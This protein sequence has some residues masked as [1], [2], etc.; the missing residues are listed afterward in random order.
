MTFYP[1][2]KYRFL[3]PF[4]DLIIRILVPEL[5]I[6]KRITDTINPESG[7]RILDF[8]CGTGTLCSLILQRAPEASIIGAD[9]DPYM[10]NLARKKYLNIQFV[11]TDGVQIPFPN[12]CFDK[13]V[14]SWTFHH[15][16]ENEKIHHLHEIL[17]VLKPGG[18]FL[19]ADWTE[20]ESFQEKLGFWLV[21]VLDNFE[22]FKD[23]QEGKIPE[24]LEK[25][26]FNL[27]PE[28]STFSTPIGKL[29]L[30]KCLKDATEYLEHI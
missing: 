17:R 21:R 18:L 12:T 15:F 13:V 26:G 7:E 6:K 14:S 29:S 10:I 24:I 28:Y 23:H 27:E 19:L 16:T 5:K 9:A 2:L 30:W 11:L 1:A 22:T 8:G 25:A 4:Y 20:P 3:T